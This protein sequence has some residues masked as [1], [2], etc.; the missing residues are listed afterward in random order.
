MSKEEAIQAEINRIKNL[1]QYKAKSSDDLETIASANLK[2]KD[3]DIGQKFTDPDEADYARKLFKKY[4]AEYPNLS[5]SQ[6]EM[7]EDLIVHQINKMFIQKQIEIGKTEKK[8]VHNSLF[9]QLREIE[10]HIF[11][12]KEKIGLNKELEVGELTATQMLQK[13]F[14]KYINE[15]REEFTT[16]CEGCGSLLLLRRRVKNFDCLQHPWFAGRW[17]FN[18]EI[19][20]DVKDGKLAKED[21]WRYMCSASKGADSKPAFSKEYCIDY[22][23]HCLKNWGD[24]TET[25]QNRE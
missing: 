13:R 8:F 24:I 11:Q 15:N 18:Y 3:T 14:D 6:V 25:L 19:L 12:L 1:P 17:F 16:V 22:I 9:D 23:D 2:K 21:A 20:K 4:L 10:E 7:I 5:Y